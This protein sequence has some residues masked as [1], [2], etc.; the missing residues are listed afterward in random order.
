MPNAAPIAK[1]LSDGS[2]FFRVSFV[3]M[4]LTPLR[5]NRAAAHHQTVGAEYSFEE[6]PKKPGA[7]CIFIATQ[8]FFL[9][10]KSPCVLSL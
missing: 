9:C 7:A 2:R 10:G 4:R 6:K 3:V 8:N 1:D 5:P